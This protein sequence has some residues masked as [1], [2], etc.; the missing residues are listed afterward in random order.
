MMRLPF[1]ASVSGR[2]L[3][4]AAELERV[5]GYTWRV[6]L[7]DFVSGRLFAAS[8]GRWRGPGSALDLGA[9]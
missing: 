6:R 5:E 1:L 7:L 2:V 4:M 8:I 9:W 3:A